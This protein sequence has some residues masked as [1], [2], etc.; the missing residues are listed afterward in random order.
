MNGSLYPAR[1]VSGHVFVCQSYQFCFFLRFFYQI[2]EFRTVYYFWF[3][4]L[5]HFSTSFQFYFYWCAESFSILLLLYQFDCL[6]YRNTRVH[7]RFLV[8]FMLLNLQF[9][10]QCVVDHCLSRCHV[11]FCPF[12]C[13]SF[14]LRF[15][16]TPLVYILSYSYFFVEIDFDQYCLAY[17]MFY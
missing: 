4:I 13:L 17:K 1:I 16:I 5:L 12:Y 2:L 6:P 15:L 14:D 9:S 11:F 8:G 3:F 7:P 10:V